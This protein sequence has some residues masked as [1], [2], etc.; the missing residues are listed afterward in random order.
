MAN[1]TKTCSLLQVEIEELLMHH[2]R[3]IEDDTDTRVER[4]NYL[5]KRLKAFKEPE[6]NTPMTASV[7]G[8]GAPNT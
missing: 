8:W 1:E 2:G 4:I 5:N 6:E 3:N 7:A